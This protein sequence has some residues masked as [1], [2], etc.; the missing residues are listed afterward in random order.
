MLD[1]GRYEEVI[2]ELGHKRAIAA[3]LAEKL[4]RA[5]RARHLGS[6]GLL[7]FIEDFWH[8][9]EP[10]RPFVTGWALAA[11]CKHLEA[12]SDGRITRLLINVPPGSMKS[13]LVNV[14]WPAWEWGPRNR[15]DLRYISFSY[16]SH[17]T[18]RDN[19]KF[20]DL[21]QSAQLKD[22][23]GDRLEWRATGKVKVSNDKTGFKFASSSEGVGT[24]ER[25][26]RV[27]YDDP[28]NVKD[29]ESELIRERTV[30][31]FKEAMSNRLNDLNKSVIIVIMQRV[32]EFDVSGAIIA[33]EM[34]YVHLCIPMEFE[35]DRRCVTRIDGKVFWADPR[36][37][38]D[39]CFWPERFDEEAVLL[40]KLQG[41]YAFCTPG[42]SPVLMA[43]LT[44]KPIRDVR[45]GDMVVGFSGVEGASDKG[46]YGQRRTKPARVGKITRSIRP[47]MKVTL[48]SG[49]VIR[50]TE[51]HKWFT[52]RSGGGTHA[53]YLPA[54]VGRDLWRVCDPELPTLS[55]EDARDAG[56]LGG[57][58]DG[59]G[60]VS[61]MKKHD[62][63]EPSA[64]V[65]FT[66]GSGRN[67]PICEKLEQVL[68]KFGLGWDC[69]ERQG[70]N[71]DQMIRWYYLT[72][73]RGHSIATMQ[74][75][76]HIAQPT[77]WRQ[78]IIDGAY[79]S[80]FLIGKE[81]VVAIEP[82]G[83][84]EVFGLTTETGNYVVWG[85]ASKNCG[86][87]QQ[88]PEPRG[89]GLFKRDAWV[90][91]EPENGKFPKFDY[92]LGSLDS[93]FTEKT[94]NDPSGFTMWGCFKDEDGNRAVIPLTAWRKHLALHGKCR[95]REK[96]EGLQLYKDAT[97]HEWGL[98]QWV[99]YEMERF[100]ADKLL[101]ENKANGHD[102]HNEMLRL[103]PAKPWSYELVD[104]AGLDKW[105]R[106]I[107]VTPFFAEGIVYTVGTKYAKLLMDEMAMFPTGRFKDMTDSTTQALWYLRQNGFLVMSEEI[108]RSMLRAAKKRK[109]LA[110]LYPT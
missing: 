59:E 88:R 52:R 102:V 80:N 5:R 64:L 78:R 107:R 90:P 55:A 74:R 86:Q 95:P 92:I 6:G 45:E 49:R 50:C 7:R 63:F 48:D 3:A 35:P 81:R 4:R 97:Q 109:A 15:P 100:K 19:Q 24:G 40:C 58:F 69:H 38:E 54:K 57:F 60:S 42:E 91:Y 70:S 34:G 20:L 44:M 85:L 30:R 22:L 41:E 14:F 98:V 99:A 26:D 108:K 83:E 76:L 17:L 66:Q 96:G 8:I 65:T 51:D 32:N 84:E 61:I 68:D 89:G 27:L 106:A 33:D 18:E 13:L 11:M 9:L 47:V 110:P 46:K 37:T 21:L 72:K 82:D 104:P 25:A 1:P 101:I 62:H 71:T 67:L 87:Y 73:P 16:A 31:F 94:Q 79:G 105:A 43:D 56:W 28:H 93:A 103:F 77:K 75:F 10:N 39:E 2:G 12:V 53:E 23:Y 36:F 29:G